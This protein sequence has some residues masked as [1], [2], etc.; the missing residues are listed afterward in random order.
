M[1]GAGQLRFVVGVVF[2]VAGT[3]LAL[4]A[5]TLAL[6]G[7]PRLGPIIGAVACI[8]AAWQL[9]RGSPIAQFLLAG[10]NVLGVCFSALMAVA[11]WNVYPL[12]AVLLLAIGALLL[13]C[14]WLLI[15]SRPLKSELK[16]RRILH[17]EAQ[18]LAFQK[19]MSE[20]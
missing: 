3:T 6:G 18:R 1:S 8:V 19:S 10:L 17:R 16:A 12:A 9:W 7:T 14:A 2:V 11:I 15:L 13:V 4:A 5:G 20:Q